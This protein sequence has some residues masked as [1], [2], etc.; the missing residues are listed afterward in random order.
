VNLLLYRRCRSSGKV[1]FLL[2]R[3]STSYWHWYCTYWV[4][5]SSWLWRQWWLCCWFCDFCHILGT[6]SVDFCCGCCQLEAVFCN[7]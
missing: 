3:T 6:V 1:S 2:C 7:L 5:R 4:R